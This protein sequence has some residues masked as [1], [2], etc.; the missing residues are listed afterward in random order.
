MP[1]PENSGIKCLDPQAA[2]GAGGTILIK[3]MRRASSEVASRLEI[4][5]LHPL[6]RPTSGRFILP[7]CGLG[8]YL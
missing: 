4:G 8:P 5:T 3:P 6:D 2:D 7:G 1:K